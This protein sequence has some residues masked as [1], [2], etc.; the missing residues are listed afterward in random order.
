MNRLTNLRPDLE[1]L[2]GRGVEV[3]VDW[4]RGEE[5]DPFTFHITEYSA[6]D[7]MGLYEFYKRV[8]FTL[9][10]VE[11]TDE[12]SQLV[13]ACTLLRNIGDIHHES[14][15]ACQDNLLQYALRRCALR[16]R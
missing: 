11:M 16:L 6:R 12:G 13:Y 5:D 15:V 2:S 7:L 10:S 14:K 1:L 8:K 4:Y 3:P 9:P